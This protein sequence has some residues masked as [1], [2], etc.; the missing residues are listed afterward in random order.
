MAVF[1]GKLTKKMSKQYKE[2]FV[3][4]LGDIP[5]RGYWGRKSQDD[6]CKDVLAAYLGILRQA[7]ESYAI[8]KLPEPAYLKTFIDIIIECL[9]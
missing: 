8:D 9:K 2:Y 7:R 1:V 3:G 5:L 4:R 6:I